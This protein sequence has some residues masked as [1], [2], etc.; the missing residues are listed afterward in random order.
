MKQCAKHV[1]DQLPNQLTR[2]NLLPDD[3]KCKDTGLN[4]AIPMVKCNKGPTRKTN[5]FEYEAAYLTSW[6][7]VS[8]KR[9]TNR[10]YGASEISNTSSIGA[11][12]SATRAKKGRG[13]R[14]VKSCYY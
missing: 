6:D 5:K 11:E 12:V 3:I 1:D 10:K 7:P 14:G 13:S 4:A 9:N 8:K 2:V